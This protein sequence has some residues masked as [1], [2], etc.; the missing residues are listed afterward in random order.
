MFSKLSSKELL[1]SLVISRD[2]ERFTRYYPISTEEFLK[3]CK[4]NNIRIDENQVKHLSEAI[5][6]SIKKMA[7]KKKTGNLRRD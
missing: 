6:Q 5:F 3:S 4:I 1:E 2:D 7:V